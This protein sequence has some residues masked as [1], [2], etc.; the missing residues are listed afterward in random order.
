MALR[1]QDQMKLFEAKWGWIMCEQQIN[2]ILLASPAS[3]NNFPYNTLDF[4]T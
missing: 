2:E 3:R 1:W 4:F